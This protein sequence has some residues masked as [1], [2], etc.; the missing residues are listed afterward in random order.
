MGRDIVEQA[1][2]L[3][4]AQLTAIITLPPASIEIAV[5]AV[6]IAPAR[7]VQGDQK[8]RLGCINHS[9][10]FPYFQLALVLI[11]RT[12]GMETAYAFPGLGRLIDG[13]TGDRHET[14]FTGAAFNFQDYHTPNEIRNPFDP[15]RSV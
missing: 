10:P 6:Q 8:W 14:H 4:R 13:G 12:L 15:G 7:Q 1:L 9:V 3:R 11:R 2:D 5:G